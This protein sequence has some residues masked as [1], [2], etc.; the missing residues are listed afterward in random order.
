MYLK[1]IQI[2]TS[3]LLLC[4][5]QTAQCSCRCKVNGPI[6]SANHMQ[7][8]VSVHHTFCIYKQ[9][10]AIHSLPH[11]PITGVRVLPLAAG[12]IHPMPLT[13]VCFGECQC[14]IHTSFKMKSIWLAHC[15]S[16]SDC[17]PNK[18]SC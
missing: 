13:T 3:F 16:L 8:G 15:A 11:W 17:P 5:A 2:S 18:T 9:L 7:S 4:R 12:A 10:F 6:K 1:C 14:H